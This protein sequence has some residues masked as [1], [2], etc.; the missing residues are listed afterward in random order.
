MFL[1]LDMFDIVNSN[2]HHNY[3][4]YNEED[5]KFIQQDFLVQRLLRNRDSLFVTR[6]FNE[7]RLVHTPYFVFLKVR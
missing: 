4:Y 3:R 2:N 1:S 5:L 7:F 6:L